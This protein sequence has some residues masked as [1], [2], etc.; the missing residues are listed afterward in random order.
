VSALGDAAINVTNDYTSIKDSLNAI[1]TQYNKLRQFASQQVKGPLGGDPVLR[2]VLN[3]IKKVLQTSNS[4]GGSYHYLA[5]IGLELTDSGD[6]QLDESKLDAAISAS[7]GNV[8]KLF[9]GMTGAD[10]VLETLQS[11][12]NSL[13]GDAGLI[14]TTRDSIQTTLTKYDDRIEQ[15][16]KLLDIRRQALQK[17]YAAAD[18]AISRLNQMNS[19]LQNW[20]KSLS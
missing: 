4:N 7:P 5:E 17:M 13:D 16:Q 18:E 2:E 8:Q 1:V 9:Q 3:D 14:K 20:I 12:L 19:S 6:M 10:G 11:T 15:Q